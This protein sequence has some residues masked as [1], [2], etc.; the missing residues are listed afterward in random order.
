MNNLHVI[1]LSPN[2]YLQNIY[3]N[4]NGILFCLGEEFLAPFL[5][6]FFHSQCSE[7]LNN[8]VPLPPEKQSQ[9]TD[10]IHSVSTLFRRISSHKNDS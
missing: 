1:S 4:Q 9:S 8:I 5:Y 10:I 2:N 7:E 3:Q 6:W